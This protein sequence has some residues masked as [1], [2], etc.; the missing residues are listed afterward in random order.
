MSNKTY[1]LAI[2]TATSSGGVALSRQGELLGSIMMKTPFRYS[3]TIIHLIDFMLHQHNVKLSDVNFLA[4]A[5]GP[6]SFTGIRVGLAC[7]KAFAQS[8][9][10]PV[11]AISTLEALAYR[12]RWHDMQVATVVEAGRH[13]I[14][15]AVYK[16]TPNLPQLKLAEQVSTL[17]HWLKTLPSGPCL[18]VGDG[19]W[20]HKEVIKKNHSEAHIVTTNNRILENMCALAELHANKGNI[21]LPHKLNGNYVRPPDAEINKKNKVNLDKK[22]QSLNPFTA[23]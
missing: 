20:R 7:I 4:V 3:Q 9:E 2:D 13:Q 11:I 14:Y 6:G 22:K 10:K 12:F 23:A 18:F 17:E 5:N 16:N 8:L 21:I 19:V 1:I 15:G